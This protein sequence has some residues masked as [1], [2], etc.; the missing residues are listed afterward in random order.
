MRNPVR[1][2]G[3]ARASGR[4]DGGRLP[5]ARGVRAIH[6]AAPGPCGRPCPKPGPGLDTPR[7]GPLTTQTHLPRMAG[8][9]IDPMVA[10]ARFRFARA[11]LDCAM[12]VMA[13]D[14][15]HPPPQRV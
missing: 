15:Q 10:V 12:E 7:A 2:D 11:R 14:R 8:G 6:G 13:D 4:L 9:R 5:P 1:A 3:L